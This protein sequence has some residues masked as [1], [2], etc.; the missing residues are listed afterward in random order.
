MRP[1]R[2]LALLSVAGAV[3]AA[4]L[5]LL[6]FGSQA[7][8]RPDAVPLAIAVPDAL[9]PAAEKI[10]AHGGDAV[11]WRVDNP[12]SA[13]KALADKEVYGVLELGGSGPTIVLSG[14]INPQGSQVAQQVLTGA[15]AAMG[16]QPRVETISPAS[17]AG[18][19]APLAASALLWICGLVAGAGLV[20]LGKRFALR[21]TAAHRLG[22][23]GGVSLAG[24]AV[25]AGFFALWDSALPLDASVLGYLLL[26]AVAFAAVQGALLRYLGIRA[27][28]ILGPLYLIAPAVAGQVPEMLNPVYRALLWSWTPFRFAAEGLR[29][30]LQGTPNA[31]DVTLGLI[32]LGSIAVVGLVAVAL[33]DR[34]KAVQPAK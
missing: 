33:P 21:A 30:L 17:T 31:P 1:S 22:L 2:L 5:G 13:R 12:E 18:R 29:S 23:I 11:S 10:A 8:A 15:A 9:R 27:M 20:V 3:V 19:T 28:A 6:T 7:S 25:V 32:V 16:S 26:I 34:V 24:V 14:A 4:V